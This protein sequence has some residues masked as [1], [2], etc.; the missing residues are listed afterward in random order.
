MIE[1]IGGKIDGAR[2]EHDTSVSA[3]VQW[4]D[5]TDFAN[6][7]PSSTEYLKRQVTIHYEE[8]DP[9]QAQYMIDQ[10]L[11]D[12]VAAEKIQQRLAGVIRVEVINVGHKQT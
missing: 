3:W 11:D 5:E 6:D 8:K 9:E 10:S 12:K 1:F 2:L 7:P 4:R